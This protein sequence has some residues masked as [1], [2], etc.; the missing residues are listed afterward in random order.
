MPYCSRCGVE[1]PSGVKQ[2]ILCSAPVQILDDNKTDNTDK[3]YPDLTVVEKERNVI[4]W[5]ITTTFFFVTA[6]AIVAIDFVF[7]RQ[8]SWSTYPVSGIIIAWSYVTLL[9]FL[10]RRQWIAISGWIIITSTF[11]VALNVIDKGHNWFLPLGLPLTFLSGAAMAIVLIVLT[12]I[13]TVNRL[14]QL[15]L[16]IIVFFCC[17]VDLTITHY[18]GNM[19]IG[20]SLI[21]FAAI[22]PI[23]IFLLFYSVYLHKR[24]NLRKYFHL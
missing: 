19:R 3:P 1:I 7:N 2:C 23:E 6:F 5:Y 14:I 24:V 15:F 22:L 9:V 18:A 17:G 10:I 13:K 11:L 16:G 20:W 12:H 21:V 4:V 8:I